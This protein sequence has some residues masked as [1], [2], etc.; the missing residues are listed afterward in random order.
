MMPWL[1]ICAGA[2]IVRHA[3]LMLALA[4]GALFFAGCSQLVGCG[5][6]CDEEFWQAAD[7]SGV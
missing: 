6:F 1:G 2:S 4:A 7:A 5:Q 3:T